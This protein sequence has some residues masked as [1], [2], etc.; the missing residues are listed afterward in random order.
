MMESMT[1]I[2]GAGVASLWEQKVGDSV[3][4][5]SLD[6]GA[7]GEGGGVPAQEQVG[8]LPGIR[9]GEFFFYIINL[10]PRF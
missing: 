4:S 9:G 8:S 6:S 3:L 2:I 7:A 5:P 1:I 10:I